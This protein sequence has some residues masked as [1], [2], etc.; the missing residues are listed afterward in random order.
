MKAKD[1]MKKYNISRN[2][3][4]N[5]VKSGKI[6]YDKT[7]S[8]RY[9]YMD[10]D[11]EK[12]EDR[13]N[14]IYARVSTSGQ[15]ENLKRQIERLKDFSASNGIIIHEI[16]SEIGSGMN[17][18]RLKYTKL[19]NMVLDNKVEKIIIEYDDRLVRFGLTGLENIFK[20]FNTELIIIN[21][22]EEG[23]LYKEITDDL[24][25]IIHHF[26]SKMYSLRKNK[27]KIVDIINENN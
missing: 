9:I 3:L 16:L 19:I 24:I 5:W 17:Y 8:G 15:S 14:I 22:S 7:K 6:L 26:S 20:K 13:I 1:V 4:T 12:I 21:K 25:S 10:K 11:I 18:N 23:D 27:K 2:T